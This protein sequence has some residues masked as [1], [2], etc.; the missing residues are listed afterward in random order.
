MV[1]RVCMDHDCDPHSNFANGLV[2]PGVV[3]SNPTSR[4][5]PGSAR[6]I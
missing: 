2:N 4:M 3:G 5:R 6:M 1:E